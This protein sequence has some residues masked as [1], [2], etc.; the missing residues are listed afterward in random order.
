MFLHIIFLHIIFFGIYLNMLAH[1]H[2]PE[3]TYKA[4]KNNIIIIMAPCQTTVRG[5]YGKFEDFET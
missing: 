3:L 5:S 4:K 1:D 2:S